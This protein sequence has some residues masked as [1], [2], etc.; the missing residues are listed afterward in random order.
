MVHNAVC[1]ESVSGLAY[2]FSTTMV[3]SVF[4]TLMIMFRAALYP[5]QEA[6]ALT[7]LS[8]CDSLELEPTGDVTD[9]SE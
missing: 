7:P 6:P 9:K 8:T 2:I 4:S 3:I 1:V 5:V